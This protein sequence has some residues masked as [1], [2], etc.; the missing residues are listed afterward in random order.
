MATTSMGAGEFEFDDAQNQTIGS[1]ARRMGLV[2]FVLVFFGLLQMINGISTLFISRNPD[3][4]LDAAEKAGMPQEQLA[5][6]KEAL[7]GNFWSSPLTVS[8]IAFTIAGLLL[9]LVGVWTRQAGIGFGG[10]VQT[11]GQDVSRLMNA[12]ESLNRTFG[13]IYYTILV[14]AIVSLVSLGVSLWHSWKG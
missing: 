13:I 9:L 14:A 2:G 11:R 6:L 4:A 3:R 7:A 10:I 12:L 8:A 1:L 5:M